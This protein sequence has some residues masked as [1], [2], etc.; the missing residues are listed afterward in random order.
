M[1]LLTEGV[2]LLFVESSWSLESNRS[3]VIES[4]LRGIKQRARRPD[5][6]EIVDQDVSVYKEPVSCHAL[7]SRR[8]PSADSDCASSRKSST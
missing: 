6:F 8:K 7:I 4:E 3:R 1:A 5:V 2:L